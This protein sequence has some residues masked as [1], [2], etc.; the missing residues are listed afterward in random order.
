MKNASEIIG[1]KK[2]VENSKEYEF[3]MDLKISEVIRYD[4]KSILKCSG[5]SCCEECGNP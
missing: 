5:P 4:T 1:Y 3:D 2:N